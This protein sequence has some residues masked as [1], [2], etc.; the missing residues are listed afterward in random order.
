MHLA[1]VAVQ[2]PRSHS[3]ICI[4]W[5]ALSDAQN[6]QSIACLTMYCWKLGRELSV[7]TPVSF[8][9]RTH[10]QM[11]V[12]LITFNFLTVYTRIDGAAF[13]QGAYL[14]RVLTTVTGCAGWA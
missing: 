13:G 8:W 5:Q 2:K 9:V 12:T 3:E 11:T 14:L 4:L 10:H 1:T 6:A 7:G